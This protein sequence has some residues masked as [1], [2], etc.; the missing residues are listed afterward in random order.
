MFGRQ[1][2]VGKKKGEQVNTGD[3][4]LKMKQLLQPVVCKVYASY[5]YGSGSQNLAIEDPEFLIQ[6]VWGVTR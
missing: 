1:I 4:F 6:Q 5:I 2:D 3:T